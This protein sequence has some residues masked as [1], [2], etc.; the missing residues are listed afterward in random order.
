MGDTISKKFIRFQGIYC[1]FPEIVDRST[2]TGLSMGLQLKD[3]EAQWGT[4][5]QSM[6]E[7]ILPFVS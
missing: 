2:E 6:V 1:A 4:D 7:V 5:I 3:D